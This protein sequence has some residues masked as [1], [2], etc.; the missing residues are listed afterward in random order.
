MVGFHDLQFA[1]QPGISATM[2][3]WA[4]LE[5]TN[6]FLENGSDVFGCSMDKSKAFDLCKFSV[7][8]RKMIKNLNLVF[9]RIIIF[10]YIHQFSNVSLG[11]QDFLQL[12]H[13]EWCGPGQ[14]P[15]RL[16][17][18]LLLLWTLCPSWEQRLR[19]QDK[20]YILWC[21]RFQWQQYFSCPVNIFPT[22]DAENCWIFLQQPWFKILNW[23]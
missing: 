16:L 19:L 10:M 13:Q 11:L 8:F 4:V 6:Y 14:D 3:T 2:C 22:R 15:G 7:L 1:Y 23:S 12:L 20:W 9:L 17:L 18:L 21:F 5:T